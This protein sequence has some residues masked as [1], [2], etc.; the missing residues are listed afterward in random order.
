MNSWF[1]FNMILQKM[2]GL[3]KK[4]WVFSFEKDK[5]TIYHM[6]SDEFSVDS[7]DELFQ[8]IETNYSIMSR[9]EEFK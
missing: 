3:S 2:L 7:F 6:H 4:G 8:F 1:S 5:L 9:V